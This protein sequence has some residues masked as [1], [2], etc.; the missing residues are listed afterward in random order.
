MGES[1]PLPSSSRSV[2]CN[3]Y[4]IVR[5][6]SKELTTTIYLSP[7][8]IIRASPSPLGDHQE[9][10]SGVLDCL[11]LLGQ[12]LPSSHIKRGA[13]KLPIVSTSNTG[14]SINRT[15]RLF[16]NPNL[17]SIR[18]GLGELLA[19]QLEDL[20][21]DRHSVHARRCHLIDSID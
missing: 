7:Q 9:P 13:T 8:V 17:K 16:E 4:F 2:I 11:F 21:S 3:L 10:W 19:V 1:S 20:S 5:A 12:Q 18:D 14:S 6:S 15:R